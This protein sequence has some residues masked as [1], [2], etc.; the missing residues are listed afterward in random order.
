[1]PEWGTMTEYIDWLTAAEAAQYLKIK[2]RTLLFWAR[3]GKIKGHT[4]SGTKRHVWRFRQ[5]D[6]DAALLGAESVL[7]SASPSVLA[8]ERSMR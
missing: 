2:P 3:N 8:K 7:N 4:L 1:M 5:R 6:L